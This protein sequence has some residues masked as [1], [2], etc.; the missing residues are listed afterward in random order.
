MSYRPPFLRGR[1]IYKPPGHHDDF[2]FLWKNTWSRGGGKT[3]L[4]IEFSWNVAT[5]SSLDGYFMDNPS[6]NGWFR[7]TP[8]LGNHHMHP[9]VKKPFQRQVFVDWFL[10]TVELMRKM[11]Y[12]TSQ[13]F[14]WCSFQ[15]NSKKK[16]HRVN[17]I[18]T[19]LWAIDQE[20]VEK[21]ENNEN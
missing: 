7:G 4:N 19:G 9:N 13:Q 21:E 16:K 5:P 2:P 14:T 10:A 17:T 15:P 3:S 11:S 20:H 12:P 1:L 18:Q 8:I 6:I